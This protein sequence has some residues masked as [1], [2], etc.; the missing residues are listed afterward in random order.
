MLFKFTRDV[1]L[2]ENEDGTTYYLYGGETN[3]GR[4]DLAM[5]AAAHEL[6]AAIQYM[7]DIPENFSVPMQCMVDFQ[8][9]RIVRWIWSTC[10]PI[11]CNAP[12]SNQQKDDCIW[13]LW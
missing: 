11:D 12:T 8:G 7:K 13:I 3:T 9:F 5:K 10:E 2:M 6:Q 1:P 4:D